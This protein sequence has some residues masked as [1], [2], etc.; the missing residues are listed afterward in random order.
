MRIASCL[1]ESRFRNEVK[2]ISKCRRVV[3][4]WSEGIRVVVKGKE[5]VEDDGADPFYGAHGER[6][7]SSRMGS[8]K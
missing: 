2:A 3:L 1:A 7:K 4:Y 5:F 8:R 6:K